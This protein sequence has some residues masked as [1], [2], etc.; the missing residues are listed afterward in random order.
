MKQ[1]N[2]TY[3]MKKVCIIFAFVTAFCLDAFAANRFKVL[4]IVLPETVAPGQNVSAHIAL[5]V[6]EVEGKN[7]LRPSGTWSF[8]ESKLSSNVSA[9]QVTPWRLLNYKVGDTLRYSLNFVV[10][11]NVKIGEMGK[12]QF[13]VRHPDSKEFVKLVGVSS[14]TFI[15]KE[16]PKVKLESPEKSGSSL[17][18]VIVPVMQEAPL[19]DGKCDDPVWN[20]AVLLP[21]KLDS[22][23]GSVT[24]YPAEVRLFT[25]LKQIYIAVRVKDSGEESRSL[26]RL[27][28]HDGKVWIN[29][30]MEFYFTPDMGRGEYAQFIADLLGQH[31]D[32]IN[33]DYYGFNPPWKSIASM[34]AKGWTMEVA[35]PVDSISPS[36]I[37]KGTVWRFNVFRFAEKGKKASCWTS[38][39]GSHSSIKNHGFLIFGSLGDALDKQG[40]FVKHITDDSSPEMRKLASQVAEVINGP[41]RSDASRLTEALTSMMAMNKKFDEL[42][43]AERFSK[44][45]MPL[46]VQNV[47]AYTG[48][49][50]PDPNSKASGLDADFFPGEVRDFAWNITNVSDKPIAIQAGFY[51]V[52]AETFAMNRKSLDY[53]YMGIPGFTAEWFA[54]SPVAALDGSIVQDVLSPN[55]AGVWR[56]APRETVQL[57]VRVRA[58][59]NVKRG[60]GALVLLGI[61][62]GTMSLATL[63]VHFKCLG[64]K[65]LGSEN[66]PFCFGFPYIPDRISK[67]RPDYARKHFDMLREYGFNVAGLSGLRHFPRPMADKQGN[68]I[69]P[70]DFSCLREHVA[71]IGNAYDYYYLDVAIWE[72]QE[73]RRD[74]FGLDFYSPAY[75]KA[76]KTWFKACADAMEEVGIPNER[77]LV[78]PL[79]ESCDNRAALIARWIKECSPRTHI[80]LDSASNDLVKMKNIDSYVDVWMP[81]FRTI[82]QDAMQEFHQYL[83]QKGNPKLLYF[84]CSGG[85]EKLKHP[86]K[87]YILK[88]FGV[89]ARDFNGLAYWAA[90]QYYGSPWYRKAYPGRTDTSL[91]YPTEAGPVP[92]RRIVAWHRGMQDLWLLRETAA[93]YKDNAEVVRKLHEAALAVFDYPNSPERAEELRQYCRALLEARDPR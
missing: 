66:K 45:E 9:Q 12:V 30:S 28:M 76:F 21:V 90:G 72:K 26:T 32:C 64:T 29:E 93:R 50:E 42:S 44:S 73:L 6:L 67:A 88:F 74:L 34:D 86:Y 77:L 89:F 68:V 19:L 24:D 14:K 8:P 57:F 37:D 23:S 25:D 63:P 81:H 65:G 87:D 7:Y 71:R 79:D 69:G 10:P 38:T 40:A 41:G 39:M 56:I 36:A 54:P 60:D 51:G 82:R 17:P 84:Y 55:P 47:F 46:V 27:P 5:E 53:L 83:E 61:D 13:R 80:I 22:G 18:A 52:P 62:G 49:V 43:F 33:G 3:D 70:M 85:N 91:L 78:C 59:G 48:V 92:S 31:Y 11:N 15:V 16:A 35:I 75:E 20:R 4:E 58:D 2:F 1:M